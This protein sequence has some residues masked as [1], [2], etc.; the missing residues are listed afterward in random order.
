M[1]KGETYIGSVVQVRDLT[2]GVNLRP[3]ATNI[4]PNQARRLVNTLISNP[5]ELGAYPGFATLSTSSLG[6][7]RAQGGR[8]VYLADTDPFTLVAD[9]GSVYKPTDGGVWGSAVDTGLNAS[10]VVDFPYDR[11]IVAWLDG[12]NTPQKSEDGSTWTQLGIS[13]PAAAPGLAVVAGGSL[14]NGNTYE[15]S[16]AYLDTSLNHLGNESA[17]AQQAVAGANL[18]VR[19]SVTASTDPQ[20]DSIRIFARDV[21]SGELVRRRSVTIANATTTED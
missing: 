15:V 5:G 7:R 10:N 21:T 16:Y 8:R 12:A 1:A 18:T 20:V 17:A 3:S 13:P 2:A 19:V 6:A 14:T 9:N 4:K 11:D